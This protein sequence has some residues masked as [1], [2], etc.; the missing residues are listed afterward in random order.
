M[1]LLHVDNLITYSITKEKA[2][3]HA[4]KRLCHDV[5][6]EEGYIKRLFSKGVIPH[7]H[8]EDSIYIIASTPSNQ[9]IGTIRMTIGYC[10][11]LEAWKGNLFPES[12]QMIASIINQGTAYEVGALAVRKDYRGS[13]VSWGLYKSALI[14]SLAHKL[15]YAI[16]GMDER[17]LRALESLGWD[18]IRIGKPKKYLGSIT[19]PGIIHVS[20]QPTKIEKKNTNYHSYLAA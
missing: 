5:Y 17:A 8:D 19:V 15:E 7:D 13:K 18:V 6:F 16:V 10:K 4:A 14:S 9:I 20:Q 3:I 12:E 2:M 1:K 11:T